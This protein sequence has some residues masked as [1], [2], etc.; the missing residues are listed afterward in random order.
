MLHFP[1]AGYNS[2]RG[3]FKLQEEGQEVNDRYVLEGTR[4]ETCALVTFIIRS[5]NT[6]VTGCLAD[7]KK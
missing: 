6:S 4:H 2:S 7:I 3:K 1:T 5:W